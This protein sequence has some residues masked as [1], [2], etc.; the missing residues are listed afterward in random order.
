MK[1]SSALKPFIR[2]PLKT[3]LAFL[4]VASASFALFSQAVGY[5]ITVQG[6]RSMEGFYH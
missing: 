4:L 3:L 2:S 6:I 1:S 5:A